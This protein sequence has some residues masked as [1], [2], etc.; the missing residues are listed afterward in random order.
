MLLASSS[1]ISPGRTRN[2]LIVSTVFLVSDT[3][4][5][6]SSNLC[7]L[8][9]MRDARKLFRLFKSLNEYQKI[10]ASLSKK[11]QEDEIELFLDVS[12]RLSFLFYWLFDNLNILSSIKFIKRDPKPYAKIGSS[13]WFLAL[14]IALVQYGRQLLFSF[15]EEARLLRK[16]KNTVE[17]AEADEIN[18]R[19]TKI[20]ANRRGIYLNLLKTLGDC[21]PAMSGAEIPQRLFKRTFN[22]GWIGVGGAISAIITSYQLY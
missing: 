16:W 17:R 7:L 15:E 1:G 22:D 14:L 8:V 18:Q 11:G 5:V 12:G 3:P 6:T 2:G 4:C 13:F 10:L 20:R 19:L 9:S 21:I